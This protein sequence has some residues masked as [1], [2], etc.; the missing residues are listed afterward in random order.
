M[1]NGA[2]S[3]GWASGRGKGLRSMCMAIMLELSSTYLLAN[4]QN[5]SRTYWH[6]R[7][8]ILCFLCHTLILTSLSLFCSA[9]PQR[10]VTTRISSGKLSE[11]STQ[12]WGNF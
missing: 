2:W 12:G 3:R 11:L 8:P 6:L 10:L 5:M 9:G 4:L 1:G 7:Y